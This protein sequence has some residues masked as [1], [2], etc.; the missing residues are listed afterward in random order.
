MAKNN[1]A[2]FKEVKAY[3]EDCISGKVVANKDRILAAQRFLNDLEDPRREMRTSYAD[4][5]IKII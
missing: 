2:L 1:S 3:A 5:V 4:Y